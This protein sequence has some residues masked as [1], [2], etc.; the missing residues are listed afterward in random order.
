MKGTIWVESEP[1]CGSTFYFTASL[2]VVK[3]PPVEKEHLESKESRADAGRGSLHILL[4]EDNMVNQKVAAR[5]LEKRGHIVEVVTT[6]L[7]AVEAVMAGS[8]DLVLMDVQMPEMGGLEATA[9]I[10]EKEKQ[11]GFGL[12]IPIVAMTAHAM[13]GDRERCLE[14]GMDDYMSKPIDPKVLYAVIGRFEAPVC[15]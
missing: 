5:L 2:G 1:G 11:T 14:A 8:F 10:R 7:Q 4:A 15:T 9:V 6:G 13:R 3:R 12:H